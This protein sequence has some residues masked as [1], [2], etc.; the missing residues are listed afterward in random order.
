MS[1]D[2]V[3][4]ILEKE[5][6]VNNPKVFTTLDL[7]EIG[8]LYREIATLRET[9]NKISESHENL[10]ENIERDIDKCYESLG[11]INTKLKGVT[12]G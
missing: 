5:V 6:G 9:R 1:R 10:I 12:N 11:K 3:R 4:E 2:K 7:Q 8:C